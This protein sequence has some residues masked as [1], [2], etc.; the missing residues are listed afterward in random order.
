L[1]ALTVLCRSS[2]DRSFKPV[3]TSTTRG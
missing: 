3:F 2:P 1:K